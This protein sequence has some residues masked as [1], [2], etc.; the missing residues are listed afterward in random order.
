MAMPATVRV[1]CNF[2]K[3]LSSNP[4]CMVRPIETIW[5]AGYPL[6]DMIN[7]KRED[8]QYPM[9]STLPRRFATNAIGTRGRMTAENTR[10]A[11]LPCNCPGRHPLRS[12]MR[13][14]VMKSKRNRIGNDD[15]APILLVSLLRASFRG[16]GGTY[17]TLGLGT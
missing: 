1:S 14:Q 8:L 3:C 7:K 12:E 6:R 17:L 13:K 16:F 10:T 15:I 5:S 4:S 9:Y 11:P 2:L